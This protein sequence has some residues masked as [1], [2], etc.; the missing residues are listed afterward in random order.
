MEMAARIRQIVAAPVFED[1]EKTRV[2]RLLNVF[3]LALLVAAVAGVVVMAIYYGLPSDSVETFTLGS[4][5]L[6]VL[7][8]SGLLI[9]VR[10]GHL[11]IASIILLSSLWL[12]MAYWIMVGAGISSDSSL[13]VFPLIIVLAGLLLG[14]R[15]AVVYTVLS[16]V[17]ALGAYLSEKAGWLV[18]VETPLTLMDLLVPAIALILTGLLLL[19]AM[20]SML[21]ALERARANEQAQSAANRELEAM[22]AS[23]EQRVVDRTHD[24]ERRSL[25]LQTAVEVSRAATSVLD[26]DK[27]IWQ[28]VEMI[29]ERFDL[30]HV[31]LFLVDASGQW[32]EY[33]AGAGAGSQLLAEEGFRLEVGGQSMVGWCTDHAQARVAQDTSSATERVEHGAVPGTRSEAALPLITRGQILGAISVQSERPGAFDDDTVASLQT[34]SDQVAVALDNARLFAESQA[35]LQAAHRAYGEF[36]REAWS[37]LLRSRGDWGLVYAQ[38]AVAPAEKEWPAHLLQAQQTG[39]LVRGQGQESALAIPLR[40]RDQVIGALGFFRDGSSGAWTAEETELLETLVHQVGVT[41]ESAQLFEQTQRRAAREQAIRHVTERM[42]RA[43]DIEA[44]LQNTVTE[45]ANTLGA[46]RAYVRLGTE[47]DSRPDDGRGGQADG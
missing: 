23:L 44:I 15:A 10:R 43:V 12:I 13:T 26:P 45:L 6:F 47:L 8:T 16:V 14:G 19:H 7:V 31:G 11:R 29:R 33:R 21:N 42:R 37:D 4:S 30:Y 36:S 20:N 34:M 2:A 46:A 25:H 41:L 1:E 3:V 39:S 27:L 40:V 22:R 9:L 24:L 28:V 38:Q 18:V 32:A 35:A 5:G 17:L